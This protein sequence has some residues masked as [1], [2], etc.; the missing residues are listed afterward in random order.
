LLKNGDEKMRKSVCLMM[1]A[2]LALAVFSFVPTLARADDG[3]EVQTTWVGV[4]GHIEQFGS[5]P[6]FG[7]LGAHAKMQTVNSTTGE[8]AEAHA[9][10]VNSTVGMIPGG[11][12]SMANF[13]Y[14]FYAA[15]LVN[16]S[17]IALNYSGYDFYLSGLWDVLKVTFVY[18]PNEKGEFDGQEYNCTI[19]PVVSNATGELHVFEGW[20]KF[21]LSIAGLDL[22]SG[23]VH[24]YFVGTVEIE[25]GDV[26]EDGA[27][28]M[29]A[30]RRGHVIPRFFFFQK[31]S[32]ESL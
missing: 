10:W 17:S 18:Y 6:A 8:W 5:N 20:T 9:C 3:M 13:T 4:S 26:D 23:S 22:V 29:H 1:V 27:A 31:K 25:I 12:F 15:W 28:C 19:E 32:P 2:V 11:N 30:L 21:D 7:W 14:S 24:H 16:S